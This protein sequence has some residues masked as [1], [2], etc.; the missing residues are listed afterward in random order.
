MKAQ[1]FPTSARVPVDEPEARRVAREQFAEALEEGRQC[2]VRD[3][4]E[5]FTILVV[6]PVTDLRIQMPYCPSIS[7]ARS[8]SSTNDGPHLFLAESRRGGRRGSVRGVR[9]GR[10]YRGRRMA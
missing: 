8:R 1:T 9:R 2:S 5:F 4:G 3:F 10:R 7:V 6:K